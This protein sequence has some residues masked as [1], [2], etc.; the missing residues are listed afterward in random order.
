MSLNA[1]EHALVHNIR[2]IC[3]EE[4]C[5]SLKVR[6]FVHSDVLLNQFEAYQV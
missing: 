3:T 4:T 2:G 1:V 5:H 6:M